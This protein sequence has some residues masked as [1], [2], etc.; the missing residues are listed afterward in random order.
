MQQSAQFSLAARFR[1]V[2]FAVRGIGRTLR[3]EPNARIHALVTVAVVGLGLAL[4]L[5]P[6]AWCALVL[7]IA[8]VWVAELLN[9]G[10]EALCD[11][12]APDPHPL[13]AKAK[14]AAAGAVLMAAFGAVLV[15]LLVLGPPLLRA[16][17]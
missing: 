10:L 9:T 14:D 16:L 13:V 11:A 3:D 17:G 12:T 1:S 2:G 15:G 4:G 8:V 6:V 7:A 5:R